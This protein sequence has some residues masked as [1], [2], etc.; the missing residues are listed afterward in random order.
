[1]KSLRE[2]V[3]RKRTRTVG[4][5]VLTAALVAVVI[6]QSWSGSPV[7]T[8]SVVEFLITGVALGSIYGVAAQGLVVTYATS[9]VFNFAQGAIGMFMAFV[10]W[11]LKVDLGLPTLLAIALTIFV[12]APLFGILVERILM[13]RLTDA[14]LVAQ[15]VV[16]IGLM[17]ALMG[18][19]ASIWDPNVSRTIPSFFGT[20]GF[21][22]GQTFL[23]W[24]RVITIAT[25]IAV[26]VGLRFLLHHTR[27]GVSMRAVVDSR[28]LTVLNGARPARASMTAWALGSSMAALAGIFLAEELSALSA[29][30]LTLFIVDAFA[31]AIIARLKSLPMAYVGGLIIGFAIS[32]QGNFLQWTGRWVN[33]P[34]A[35]P[36]VILFVA[37]LFVPHSRIEGRPKPRKNTERLPTMRRALLGF[38]V[39]FVASLVCAAVL[40]RTNIRDV[41]LA[42]LTSFVML[43]LVPLTGWA[44]QISLGQ[45]TLV[46]CGAFAFVEWGHGG[47]LGLL[48]AAAFA[49]PVGL[50]MA[51]PA[52]RLQGLYLA[53]STMA[54][55]RM[56]EFLFFDQPSVFGGSDRTVSTFSFFGMHPNSGFRFLGISVPPDGGFLIFVTAAFCIIGMFVVWI[57]QRP[58]GRRL[59]AVR[60]S[61]LASST[62]G[63]NLTRTKFAVFAF[64]AAIAGLAGALMAIFYG[65]V[66]T[67]DFQVTVG[68]PYLLLLVVGGVAV[69]SGA[70]FGGLALVSFSWLTSAFPGSTFLRWFQEVGPGLAGIGIG[71]NPDGAVPDISN[72]LAKRFLREHKEP[73]PAEDVALSA[74]PTLAP[75][76]NPDAPV[77]ELQGINVRFGGL[78]AVHEVDLMLAEG[79]ITGL[80]GPNG[81][82]KTTLFN[83]AT[84]LQEP[85]N[86]RIFF[87]GED[88]TGARPHHLA[89][90]GVARTFQRLETFGSLSVRDN[91]RVAAE[92]RRNWSHDRS[93][94]PDPVTDAVLARVG[95]QSVAS[96]R[97]DTLPTGTARLLEV[98][99]ALATQPRALL[100]DEPSSGLNASESETLAV[101]LREL[102]ASGIA[103]LLVE[104][105][106]GFIMDLCAHIVVL[107]AGEVIAQGTPKEV[108]AD[109][110][111]LAAYLGT[112]PDE[113]ETSPVPIPVA[114]PARAREPVPDAPTSDGE[115]GGSVSPALELSGVSAGYG[116][117]RV[118][119]DVDL[120]VQRGEVCALLGPNGAGKSTTLKV[121][122]GQLRPTSGTAVV[123]GRSIA[124]SS[125]DRLV[126]EGL[127]V[128]PEGRG[129][130]PN[131]T[132]IDNL[133][134]ATFVGVDLSEILDMSFE[135][136]PVL[137]QRRRQLA[138]TLSGGEQQMLAIARALAVR[139]SILLLDELSMGLAPL[140]VEQLY[141][142]IAGIAEEG[143]S[144]LIVEQFA[145]EVLKVADVAALLVNGRITYRGRPGDIDDVINAA[146]LGYA[147]ALETG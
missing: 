73:A 43:S 108:Q 21:H 63:L 91:V 7:T 140:V 56:A 17:L 29:S 82:G 68:L 33:A 139:P 119:F 72:R 52:L 136:F 129:V 3:G 49:I 109:P 77:L 81:A 40:S 137:A 27:L 93:F 138:G 145:H 38:A 83:V 53:L 118:L 34:S 15:L 125:T 113:V 76:K 37:L 20:S 19:A 130:F 79:M 87:D 64:S 41:L 90:L 46:G 31:A 8:S 11:E 36:A 116:A 120:V 92:T 102:A 18:L 51:G 67:T 106:M 35:I 110:V 98:A 141:E 65:S 132:V 88:V 16:T 107:D 117:I 45:I 10:Y 54:F 71:R 44:N 24:Y 59:I 123:N 78:Q 58:F 135:R 133:K 42:M 14:P 122:S 69:V 23:P 2:A 13:R 74:L 142:V 101:L 104:H 50:V 124:D 96:V 114:V 55:A 100:L 86:G 39:L 9:G 5:A 80:I 115:T 97:A 147:P 32:F 89:R 61:P 22:I 25:G 121:A 26:G 1:M 70:V 60:D 66:S 84:G 47:A 6:Q 85:D 62:L 126:R 48:A 4:A 12:L 30:T 128:V 127:C 94:R 103:I 146:Y 95:L 134:M 131:L 105:D 28:E 99:R 144:L 112:A 57:R 111:V 143:L 75:R